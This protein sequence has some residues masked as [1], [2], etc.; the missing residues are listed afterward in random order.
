M[1]VY[2]VLASYSSILILCCLLY[3]KGMSSVFDEAVTAVLTS[4]KN[5]KKKE[6]C[7]VYSSMNAKYT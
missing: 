2:T 3:F 1:S 5:D 4:Q 6:N 7:T